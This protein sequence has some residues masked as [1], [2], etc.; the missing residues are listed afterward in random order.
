MRQRLF[1]CVFALDAFE[2]KKNTQRG[3][4]PPTSYLFCQCALHHRILLGDIFQHHIINARGLSN[5]LPF[6]PKKRGGEMVKNHEPVEFH[7]TSLLLKFSFFALQ[8]I[9]SQL[10]LQAYKYRQLRISS[11]AREKERKK[12]RKTRYQSSTSGVPKRKKARK[13]HSKSSISGVPRYSSAPGAAAGRTG[14][15][16]VRRGSN[17]RNRTVRR[18]FDRGQGVLVVVVVVQSA[19]RAQSAPRPP[20]V[21]PRVRRGC[22]HTRTCDQ[23]P[24]ANN[25][26]FTYEFTQL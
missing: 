8:T 13:T 5:T 11:R 17:R 2:K 4:H 3:V 14:D 9:M 18:L 10:H 21:S 23:G 22:T 16:C 7:I 25:Q 19:D 15:S 26:S 12:A 20:R 1:L 24:E 6:P